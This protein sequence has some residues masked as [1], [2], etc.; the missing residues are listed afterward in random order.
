MALRAPGDEREKEVGYMSHKSKIYLVRT[1]LQTA[2]DY[3]LT[4]RPF[5]TGV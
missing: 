5:A 4:R 2:I 3:I 1:L